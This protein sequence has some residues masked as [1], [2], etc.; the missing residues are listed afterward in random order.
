MRKLTVVAAV[1]VT[2]TLGLGASTKK[3]E[4]YE[5]DH[6][7]AL[8]VWFKDKAEHKAYLKLKT[9]TERDQWLKDKGYW[10]YFYKY[11]EYDRAAILSREP[12]IGWTQDMLYMAWGP[13]FHKVKS[14]KRTAQE[15]TILKYRMEVSKDGRHMVWEPKS[16][17]TYKAVRRYQ[18]DIY[19]DDRKIVKIEEKDA[20]EL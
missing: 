12:K 17:E 9:N 7:A 20:W 4:S 8:S 11:D 14:T 15:S 5:K 18:T 19:L 6:Y 16:S 10:D 2:L 13:P 3:L 1:L